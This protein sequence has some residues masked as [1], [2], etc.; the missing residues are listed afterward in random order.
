MYLSTQPCK[1]KF[2]TKR[3]GS[4]CQP[5]FYLDFE[6]GEEAV[7]STSGLRGMPPKKNLDCCFAKPQPY[8]VIYQNVV[9]E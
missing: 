4:S 3:L 8:T 7:Q 1:T 6:S 5:G 9:W 2:S